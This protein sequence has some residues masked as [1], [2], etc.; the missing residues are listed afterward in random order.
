[1]EPFY[2]AQISINN[3]CYA[4]TQTAGEINQ[5]DMIR[6]DSYDLSLLGKTWQDGQ[7][8]SPPEV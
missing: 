5:Q 7:W 1:M 2:Y 6:I 8:I 4:V 3:Q